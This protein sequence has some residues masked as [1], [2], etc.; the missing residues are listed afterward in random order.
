M[1]ARKKTCTY[2]KSAL[3]AAVREVHKGKSLSKVART[4][5][6]PKTTIYDHTHGHL[7]NTYRKPGIARSLN[8]EEEAALVRYIKYMAERGTPLTK[9]L[10]QKF[11]SAIIRRSGRPS[12]INLVKGPSQKWCRKFFARHTE[13]KRRRPDKTDSGRLRVTREEVEDYFMVLGDLLKGSEVILPPSQIFNCDETGFDGKESSKEKVITVGSQHPYQH[14]TCTGIG[15]ITLQL[16]VSAGG[17]YLPPM[18]IFSKNLPRDL[19]SL[20]DSWK[21]VSSSKGYMDSDLFVQWLEES[22]IPHCGRA[23]PVLLIM[24]NLGAHMTPRA[25]DVAKANGIELLCLPPHSTHL[26]QP[27]DVRIF[28]LLKHNIAKVASRLGFQLSRVTRGQ[29]PALIKYALSMLSENDIFEAFRLTGIHP[30]NPAV[31]DSLKQVLL[32]KSDKERLENPN[33]LVEMDIVPA[34]LADILIPPAP[35]PTGRKRIEGARVIT[36]VP[37]NPI[38]STSRADESNALDEE[39]P[40]QPVEQYP[41]DGICVV[42]MTNRRLEWVGCDVCPNWFHYACLNTENRVLVDLSFVSGDKWRCGFCEEE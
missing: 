17:H 7:K 20:P 19:A 28:H 42:C 23:R 15:H 4:F 26:L 3:M 10:L 1:M 32:T 8:D 12:R 30:F 5:G 6:I 29:L 9:S 14:Q 16:A 24:D 11:V 2:E 41:N 27:L 22:F 31:V 36:K 13:L 38:P 40:Y 21:C 37:A 33:H 35:R 18:L 39:E 25:I 34:A